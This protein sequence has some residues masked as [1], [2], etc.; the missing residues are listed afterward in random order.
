VAQLSKVVMMYARVEATTQMLAFNGLIHLV[1]YHRASMGKD[2]EKV[3][4]VLES[5]IKHMYLEFTK[6]SRTGGGGFAI[7]SN[8]RI[9]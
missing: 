3:D 7:Q 5:C 1:A 6:E 4:Q 2:E 8:L 9:A